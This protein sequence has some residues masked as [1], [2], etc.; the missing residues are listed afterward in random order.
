M[1]FVAHSTPPPI[2]KIG[3]KDR[4]GWREKERVKEIVTV[5]TGGVS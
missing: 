5:V 3:G 2:L 4:E 1:L